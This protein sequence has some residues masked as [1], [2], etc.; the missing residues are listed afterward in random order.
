MIAGPGKPQLHLS[1]SVRAPLQ[2]RRFTKV[3]I[4]ERGPPEARLIR[5]PARPPGRRGRRRY[6]RGIC[7]RRLLRV[8]QI[9]DQL[10]RAV[11]HCPGDL[12]VDRARYP[13]P[14]TIG[15]RIEQLLLIAR[16][17]V[18]GVIERAVEHCLVITGRGQRAHQLS[19]ER[20]QRH[21]A[22]LRPERAARNAFSWLSSVA[23]SS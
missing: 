11:Q 14:S 10:G 18:A 5:R 19:D 1:A 3:A 9:L 12:A 13:P 21:A 23:R 6:S 16:Q 2:R 17:E 8:A 15:Y 22:E 20:R 7:H 4:V